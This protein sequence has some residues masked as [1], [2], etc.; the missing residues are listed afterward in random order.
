MSEIFSQFAMVGQLGLSLLMPLLMCL[1][2]CY[3]LCTRLSVGAWVYIPG[4]VMGLGGSMTTA[5]KVYLAVIHREE[6]KKKEKAKSE[7]SFNRHI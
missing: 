4:F 6:K 3:L 1:F 7:V 2:V 5:Y